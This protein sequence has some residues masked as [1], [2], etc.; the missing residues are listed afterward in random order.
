MDADV[1]IVGAGVIGLACAAASVSKGFTTILVEQHN[2]FGQETS[3][4]NSEV[5]HSGIYY[6]PG[7]W[8]ARLCVRGNRMMYAE[9]ARLGVWHRRC[10]K[11]I[12]AVAEDEEPELQKLYERGHENGVEGLELLTKE[13]AQR[14]EPYIYC[15]AALHVPSTGIVDSHEL[16]KAYATEAVQHDA[17]IVYG[18]QFIGAARH[19][20]GYA[21]RLREVSGDETKIET[22][23]IV[24]AAG[25]YADQ[26]AASFGIDINTAGYRLYPNRG[27]YFRVSA[28]KSRLV[29]RLIYPIPPR[30]KEGLGIHVT[31]DRAGQCKLGPDTEYIDSSIPASEWYRFD[32]SRKERFH[33]AASRYFPAI[34]L[35]DLSPDQVG[36]R[37][38]LQQPGGNILDFI[39]QEEEARG[40]PG[41][42]N[43]IGIES[44]GLT[45]APAIAQEVVR[46]MAA[47]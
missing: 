34:E 9:C 44:P 2:S 3:S 27:H 7:S 22:R 10:G 12:V 40:L 14:I 19:A 42:I 39:I 37:P 8:K 21:V 35:D 33:Q 46:L 1:V 13:Q 26:V 16:M 24:N 4:R 25:L 45:C 5:I 47:Q 6:L 11:L 15:Q 31:V 36:V 29:S 30:N 43:L 41:L 38:K 18:V 17:T 32:E 28:T 23:T 20:T